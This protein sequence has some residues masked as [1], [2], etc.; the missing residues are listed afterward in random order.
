MLTCVLT[1]EKKK[2]YCFLRLCLRHLHL[3]SLVF[4]DLDLAPASSLRL[5]PNSVNSLVLK[6]AGPDKGVL[7]PVTLLLLLL[8]NTILCR[9]SET[10]KNRSIWFCSV[11]CLVL[12][13]SFYKPNKSFA[14]GGHMVLH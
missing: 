4:S 11:C 9:R 14:A 7:L 13:V 10:D 2:I 5:R 1:Q 12:Y 6:P 3:E 8:L